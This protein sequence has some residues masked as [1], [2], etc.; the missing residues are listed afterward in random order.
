MNRIIYIAT[1][2][3]SKLENFK[4]FFAWID[5]EIQVERVPD[6]VE[7]EET[8]TTLA[9][10]SRLKVLPYTGK[11][12]YPVIANDSG[13]A[14]DSK[15]TE[16]Q[17]PVKV[18]RNAL[19]DVPETSLSQ[20]EISERM[21]NYY[22]TIARKYGGKVPCVMSD[23]FTVL[24][25]DGSIEQQETTREY[26][27]V[28]RD[29]KE[30]DLYHPLNSLRIS[31]RTN[32]YMDEMDEENDKIDKQV[33]VEALKGLINGLSTP[34]RNAKLPNIV[35]K[36]SSKAKTLALWI[37][38][39]GMA[40]TA[41]YFLMVFLQILFPDGF[42]GAGANVSEEVRYSW[43][44][45]FLISLAFTLL[46]IINIRNQPKVAPLLLA[47]ILLYSVYLVSY[48]FTFFKDSHTFDET[49]LISSIGTTVI[50][51]ILLYLPYVFWTV[52]NSVALIYN[53]K[54]SHNISKKLY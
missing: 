12:Q 43:I 49:N 36:N 50:S 54:L 23:A 9:E 15:V 20:E 33:L 38:F 31:P 53:Y 16:I 10:N 25:P 4:L 26:F 5:P 1:G 21:F 41:F 6:Y 19:G 32:M 48:T 30:Y 40:E 35:A 39:A 44:V 8:G 7:V 52:S 11:Y 14:F 3:K 42:M 22:R 28:D 29:T 13:L 2:N 24:Y 37:A 27:L 45:G 34:L 18:K 51:A 47:K 46:Y 17:D